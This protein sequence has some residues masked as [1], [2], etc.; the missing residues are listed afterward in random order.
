MQHVCAA[1]FLWRMGKDWQD[2][3]FFCTQVN[4]LN[5]I[6]SS[7]YEYYEPIPAKGEQEAASS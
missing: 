6:Q 7:A 1:S 4:S 3:Y 5:E 2:K